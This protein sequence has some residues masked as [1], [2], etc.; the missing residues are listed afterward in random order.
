MV[1]ISPKKAEDEA[2]DIL[3]RVI[4]EKRNVSEFENARIINCLDSLK[5]REVHL[6][7][8]SLLAIT[9]RLQI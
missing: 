7:M 6:M 9:R 3:N 4:G 8:K 2:L 1:S 5:G